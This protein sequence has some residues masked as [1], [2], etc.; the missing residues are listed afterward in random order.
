MKGKD[1]KSLIVLREKHQVDTYIGEIIRQ[2]MPVKVVIDETIVL[3]DCRLVLRGDEKKDLSIEAAPA[4]GEYPEAGRATVTCAGDSSFYSF[5][6]EV[7][8]IELTEH[9]RMRLK[10]RYPERVTKRE[11]R[12]HVR[13]PPSVTEPVAARLVV[14]GGDVVDVEPVDMSIGGISFMMTE[15]VSRFKTGTAVDLVIKVPPASEVHARAFVRSVI[16]LM[17]LTRV[18]VEFASMSEEARKDIADYIK[19]RERQMGLKLFE[20]D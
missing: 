19:E 13:V 7:L 15:E 14:P 5:G 10:M 6:T 17:D 4:P 12:R 1:K 2:N 3:G 20:E 11:R 8:S 16:H 9:R 18:G